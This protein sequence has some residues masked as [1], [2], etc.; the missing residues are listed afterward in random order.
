MAEK[1]YTFQGQLIPTITPDKWLNLTTSRQIKAGRKDFVYLDEP[2]VTGPRDIIDAFK[3]ENNIIERKSITTV[4][5]SN[6]SPRT[7]I[8]PMK[9]MTI[10]PSSIVRQQISPTIVSLKPVILQKTVVSPTKSIDHKLPPRN[11]ELLSRFVTREKETKPFIQTIIPMKDEEGI[12]VPTTECQEEGNVG[13]VIYYPDSTDIEDISVEHLNSL[14]NF[15]LLGLKAK[16]KILKVIDGDT[17]DVAFFV[18]FKALA[19]PRTVTFDRR[20]VIKSAALTFKGEKGFFTRMRCRLY[21][22]DAAEHDTLQGLKALEI[23]IKEYNRTNNIVY[24]IFQKFDMYGRGLIEI[25]R[26]IGFLH[27]LNRF[28]VEYRDPA[29]QPNILAVEYF[30]DTKSDYMKQLPK[31]PKK[32]R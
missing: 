23:M 29:L 27:S 6:L 20:K 19:E 13:S 28:I 17:V 25:F 22:I 26:D 30:G 1:Q 10:Q 32:K 18:P 9:A 15:S 11:Y 31:I 5:P 3:T 12:V 24:V 4:Q 16:A 2:R 14:C 8:T 7:L 21:G